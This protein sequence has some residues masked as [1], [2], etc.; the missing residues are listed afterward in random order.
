M[1]LTLFERVPWTEPK[2]P[3][4]SKG[5]MGFHTSG[6]KCHVFQT[7]KV[8]IKSWLNHGLSQV[9]LSLGYTQFVCILGLFGQTADKS[10]IYHCEVVTRVPLLMRI[11]NHHKTLGE[12]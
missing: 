3:I 1:P 8:S 4:F 10:P 9:L 5:E 6:K 7:L 11:R 2:D 12:M